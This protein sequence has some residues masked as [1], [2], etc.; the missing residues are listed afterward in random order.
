V[1]ILAKQPISV[2]FP[3][4][5]IT[6]MDNEC[7]GL[8]CNRTDFI[9]N[10]VEEKLQESTNEPEGQVIKDT[11]PEPAKP[12]IIT[13][14]T[15]PKASWKLYDDNGNLVSSSEDTKPKVTIDLETEPK[16]I[17]NSNKPQIEMVEFNGKYI[18]KA[19]VY[20]I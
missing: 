15:K 8:G 17:D 18:P 10:A 16:K 13:D 19:E 1:N 4:E 7:E 14:A 20:Q 9:I 2:K 6:D 12:K 3:K 11:K 5:L